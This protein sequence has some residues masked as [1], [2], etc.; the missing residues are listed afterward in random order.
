MAND[1]EADFSDMV[2]ESKLLT[3]MA[4]DQWTAFGELHHVALKD[5]ALDRKTKELIALGMGIAQQCDGCIMAHTRSALKAGASKAEIAD[6]AGVA[7][8]MCGG[9][10]TVY[11]GKAVA[12]A[13]QFASY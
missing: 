12:A 10:G 4:G 11:G 8:L 7:F 3:K 2:D 1:Y 9:P 6:V 13:E 5:G